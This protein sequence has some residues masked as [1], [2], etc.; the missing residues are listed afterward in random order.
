MLETLGIPNS[1]LGAPGGPPASTCLGNLVLRRLSHLNLLEDPLVQ[2]SQEVDMPRLAQG[3]N[4]R[5]ADIPRP[6]W[7]YSV[8]RRC[9]VSTCLGICTLTQGPP[10]FRLR[11][12]WVGQAS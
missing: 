11:Q 6:A 2:G 3:S 9:H 4:S 7:G 5:E 10:A 1:S 12:Y 8:S